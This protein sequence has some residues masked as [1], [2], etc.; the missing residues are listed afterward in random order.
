[1]SLFYASVRI[2]KNGEPF[3]MWKIRTL[4]EGSDSSS[5]VSKDQYTWCGRF[6]RKWRIDE[7]AQLWNVLRGEMS[8]VGP[9]PLEY[10]T[11]TLYPRDT[12]RKLLSVKPGMFGLAGIYFMDEERLLQLSQDPQKD[13]WEKIAPIKLALDFFYIENKCFSL[14]LWIVWHGIKRRITTWNSQ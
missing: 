7:I 4:K 3:T 9:R 11:S 1:M 2:G 8:L 6:L 12:V 13:Y 14:D 10:K 5:F